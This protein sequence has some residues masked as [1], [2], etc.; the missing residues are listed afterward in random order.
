MYQKDQWIKS[1]NENSG[2]RPDEGAL[3]GEVRG[4]KVGRDQRKVVNQEG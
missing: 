2:E 4:A 3:V 1:D